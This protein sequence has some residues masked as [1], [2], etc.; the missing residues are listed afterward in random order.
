PDI[1]NIAIGDGR[2]A[3]V[4]VTP[5][6]YEV[7]GINSRAEL[8]EADARW[9]QRR[10]QRAMAEGATLRAPETVWF[11]WDTVLGR[12]VIIEQNVIFGPGV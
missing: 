1:V 5:D 9:Q 2:K 7:A 6:A 11:A 8:A 4:V 10:R 12:D 3:A